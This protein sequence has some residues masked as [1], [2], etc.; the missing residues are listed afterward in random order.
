MM[1]LASIIVGRRCV[2]TRDALLCS[3]G[4]FAHRYE[5][6]FLESETPRPLTRQAS[7]LS[8]FRFFA[9]KTVSNLHSPIEI[10]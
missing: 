6:F 1:Q 3:T 4:G 2:Q 10:P 9:A 7:R 5:L 8:S